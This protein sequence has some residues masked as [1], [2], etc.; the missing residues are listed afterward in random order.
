MSRQ[1]QITQERRRRNPEA[2]KGHRNRL[3]LDRSKLDPNFEYRWINNEPG[4]IETLTQQDDWEVVADRDRAIK[5]DSTG[6]GSEASVHAGV[7]EAGAPLRTVLCRKLKKYYEDDERAKQRLIDETEASI[8]RGSTPGAAQD[9]QFYQ[10]Q[11][12]PIRID[13]AS[14]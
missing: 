10:P 9:G 13:R 8:R 6:T 5:A 2:L 11:H 1:E 12:T 4:R 3:W 14:G 7:G